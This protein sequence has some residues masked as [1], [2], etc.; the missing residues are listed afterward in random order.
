MNRTSISVIQDFL[1]FTQTTNGEKLNVAQSETQGTVMSGLEGGRVG[2]DWHT[3]VCVCVSIRGKR[4]GAVYTFDSP[5]PYCLVERRKQK[6]KQ[7]QWLNFAP[8]AFWY[9][10]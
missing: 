6:G 2:G 5:A 3:L 7:V 9:K 8:S 4:K 10:I 1:S